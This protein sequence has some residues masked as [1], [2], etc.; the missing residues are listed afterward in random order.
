MA[1][2]SLQESAATLDRLAP[3]MLWVVMGSV[4]VLALAGLGVLAM[5]RASAAARHEVWLLASASVL[6]LPILATTLPSW[7]VL[8]RLTT[9]D[10]P[11]ADET[12]VEFV[13][14]AGFLLPPSHVM[15]SAL[16]S[17]IPTPGP[18]LTTQDEKTGIDATSDSPR[19]TSSTE[20]VTLWSR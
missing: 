8:P 3:G 7:H 1:L 12:L 16:P 6:L 4:L 17:A 14:Q 5:R 19:P 20:A 18:T 15:S 9:T 10:A 13:P 11:R 2:P